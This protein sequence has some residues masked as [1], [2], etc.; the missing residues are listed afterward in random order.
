MLRDHSF[1]Y[2]WPHLFRNECQD[3]I[4]CGDFNAILRSEERWGSNGFGEASEEFVGF[5]DL[6]GL[7]D[8]PLQGSSFTYFCSGPSG[9]R[10]RLD[11]F[12]VSSKA[13]N[14]CH[15]M[16][17][18]AEFKLVSD[19]ISIL[20]SSGQFSFGPKPFRFFNIWCADQKF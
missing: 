18:K 5:V 9:A 14:W 4:I 7:A 15:N 8:L 16:L 10:S 3:F 11:R 12:L 6:L 1:S 19:H 17:Q 2:P 20:L 13:G